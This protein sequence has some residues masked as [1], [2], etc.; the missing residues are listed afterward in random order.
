[1][2]LTGAPDLITSQLE[3]NRNLDVNGEPKALRKCS[4]VCTIGPKTNSVE[5]ISALRDA[6]MNVLRMNFSHG[7]YEY[8]GSVVANA[9]ASKAKNGRVLAIALDT[10][11]PEIRTGQTVGDVEVRVVVDACYVAAPHTVAAVD[12]ACLPQIPIPAGHVMTFS[13]DEK[14]FAAG[15]KEVMFVDYKNLPK[16]TDVGKLIFVDDG[17]LSFEVLEV[18]AD[19][20]KVRSQN[21]GKLASKKG[22]NLPNTDVDLPAVSEKDKKDLLWGVEQGVDMIF[23]SFIRRA[24]DVHQIRSVL[25]EKGKNIKI[26]VKIEN[27]QGVNNFDEI[28]EATDGVMVARGVRHSFF[29][30]SCFLLSEASAVRCVS[31]TSALTSLT[32]A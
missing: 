17:I 22:V 11:G 6:G 31:N 12:Q 29:L 26:I 32:L 21:A 19:Y 28:L 8:H 20:V 27:M 9:R 30:T 13:M 18:G 10:K 7:S 3:W 16:V 15:S 14:H 24:A 23:A 1:M 4:I 5:M 25:G 2:T